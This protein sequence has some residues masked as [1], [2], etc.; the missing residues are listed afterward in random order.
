MWKIE[1]FKSHFKA[2]LVPE[3]FAYD[4]GTNT[5]WETVESLRA[6][7]IEHVDPTFEV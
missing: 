4:S 2:N 6:L 5:E 3:G 7:I 1:D